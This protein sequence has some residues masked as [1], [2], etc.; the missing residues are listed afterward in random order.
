MNQ[1]TL[2]RYPYQDGCR[3]SYA[4]WLKLTQPGMELY[5]G[6][7]VTYRDEGHDRHLAQL[8]IDTTK[9]ILTLTGWEVSGDV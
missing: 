9:L 5:H 1:A 7:V 8:M 6:P 3:K 4:I 2:T